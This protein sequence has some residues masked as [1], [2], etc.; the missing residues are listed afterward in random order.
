[1]QKMKIL[2]LGG[3][4]SQIN[5]IK[6]GLSRGH[7]IIVSDKNPKAPGCALA[8]RSEPVSTFDCPGT[9]EIVKKHGIE[10]I[11]VVG[12]DQPVYT[13]AWASARA[14]IRYNLSEET[15]LAVT[16]KGVMK[17]AL[18]ACGLPVPRYRI[19]R[20]DFSPQELS[21]L[22]FPLVI[23][24]LDSQGQRGVRKAESPQE[25]KTLFPESL[26]F[27]RQK[28]LLAEE[29]YPHR[30]VTVSGWVEDNAIS[31][32]TI[33]DRVTINAPPS[34][35]VC[36]AH[37][38]PSVYAE[39]K[40]REITRLVEK[41]T[42]ALNIKSGPLYIQLFIGE[43]G[44]VINETACR[45]GGAYEDEWIPLV[46]GADPLD[47]L[48][49]MTETGRVREESLRLNRAVSEPFCTT[50]LLFSHPGMITSQGQRDEILALPGVRAGGYLLDPPVCIEELRNSTQRAGY[51][52]VTAGTERELDSRVKELFNH[53]R[54]F[55]KFGNNLLR[56]VRKEVKRG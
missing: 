49:E 25:I 38:V 14:G 10:G 36:I 33:S 19:L 22:S 39:G 17:E 7:R 24:P 37:R 4:S 8:D 3:G 26:S 30:E 41:I 9:L 6:R 13:A 31:I 47:L 5:A 29:F 16:N 34:L 20:E 43:R 45:L 53:F 12:T 28:E 51:A 55:D 48:Y 54:L 32:F 50:L 46:T 15:A 21:G 18:T 11:L 1:M 56:D 35:G 23:K 27:S 2:I 40:E 42:A 44:I 52:I